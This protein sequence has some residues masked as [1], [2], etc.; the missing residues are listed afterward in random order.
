[1]SMNRREFLQGTIATG[2]LLPN[3]PF[4]GSEQ[5][6]EFN[7]VMLMS[8]EHNPKYSS[9][10][11][12]PFVQTPNLERMA[13]KGV[14]FE[15][16]YCP[17][18]LCMPSRSSVM[19]GLYNHETR[20]YSNCT[21]FLDD[22][23][24]YG[25]VLAEQGVHTVYVGKA[26]V[27]RKIEEMGFSEVYHGW[28]RGVPGD[29]SIERKPLFIRKGAGKD[30][31]KGWG[32]RE[33]PH[34]KDRL[35]VDTAVEWLKTKGVQM[36]KPFVLWANILP[37]HF[38]HFT[39]PKYWEM[40]EGKG[41]FPKYGPDEE[42]AKHPYAVDL[43]T[44]FETDQIQGEDVLRL[45]QGYYGCVSFVDEM[46]GK[47]LDALE[48]TGLEKNTIF[49][50]T[51][52]H[53]EMLGKFGMWWKCSMFE[54]S[55]QVPVVACGPGFEKGL[56]VRT[57]I[58]TLDVQAGFFHA[59]QRKRPSNWK[60]ESLQTLQKEAP[61]RYVFSEYH[62]HGTRGSSFMVRKDGWKFIWN[63][64]APHQLFNLNEDPEEL[65]N[66]IKEDLST[67]PAIARELN[68]YLYSICDPVAETQKAEEKIQRQLAELRRMG[69][70]A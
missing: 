32:P 60:G 44:H 7:V 20:C 34:R 52:D 61:N 56:R 21:L 37:P 16:A 27:Y 53:G 1:M 58:T 30:R 31:A 5:E 46:I 63:S 10:Y 11:G 17:S 24:N 36:K 42:S 49:I 68:D 33:N 4:C 23:P 19:S 62:G 57:P 26:D 18:P 29:E 40:Y 12:H 51:S 39:D 67:A 6:K 50:Y 15:N 47:I 59:T 55:L 69:K 14:V 45:R 13:K 65:K 70:I 64:D 48:E 3:L 66:L 25:A 54:D 41:D 9:V 8:D 28:N 22:F 2:L 35:M 38:P 43:R